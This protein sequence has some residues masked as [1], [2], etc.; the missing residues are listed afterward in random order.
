MADVYETLL[1]LNHS[2]DLPADDLSE[3]RW[4]LGLETREFVDR[5]A[6]VDDEDYW[7]AVGE[8]PLLTQREP[9][10]KIGGMRLSGLVHSEQG[11][12]LTARQECTS[13]DLPVL[14][15]LLDRLAPSVTSFGPI[16]QLRFYEELTP[17][18]LIIQGGKVARLFDWSAPLADAE[19]FLDS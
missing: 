9:A 2:D 17:N 4:H 5:D 15:G 13:E 18:L 16:G 10:W 11:W 14:Q 8:E 12:S 1:A 7:P 3:L 19:P 6:D